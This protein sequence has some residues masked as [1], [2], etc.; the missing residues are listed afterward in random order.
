LVTGQEWLPVE[1][2]DY[3]WAGCN[4]LACRECGVQV[5]TLLGF[6]LPP[7]HEAAD[8][9]ALIGA[10]D[11]SRFVESPN[12]RVYTCRHYSIVATYSFPAEQ[13][14]DMA[15]WTPWGCAGHPRL[16]LPAVLEGLAVDDDSDWRQLARQSFAGKLSVTLHPS[17][18]R[19]SGFWIHRLYQLLDERPAIG[20]AAADLL[21]D[22]DPR[23]R[24]GAIAFFRLNGNATGAER[25]A[26]ALRDHPELFV[27][28]L[29]GGDS[30][31]LERQLLDVLDYRI[32][33]R[34]GD[35]VA[36]ELMRAAL[37]R[38]FQHV[39]GEQYLFGMARGD[40]KWL[41]EHGD[42]LVAAVPELWQKMK[43][44]LASAGA[45]KRQMAKLKDRVRA[46]RAVA[47]P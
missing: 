39:G 35:T 18:D 38:R 16:S 43:A 45:S 12:H 44:A 6:D 10:N 19:D 34:I 11:H 4:R 3:L 28:F 32:S 36:V 13:Q 33:N 7:D 20:N 30:L 26:T 1:P 2:F 21:L 22:S 27:D 17:V 41:L 15:S 47:P 46:R 23:V 31:T 24:R 29:V 14:H 8:A 5:R 42:E 37:S 9:Y 25:T 40:Q